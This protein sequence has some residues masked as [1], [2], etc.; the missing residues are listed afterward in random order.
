LICH[1]NVGLLELEDIAEARDGED[2]TDIIVNT[3]DID[4]TA[5]GLSV[6]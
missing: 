3:F 4:M 1:V 5:F 2:S 6:L